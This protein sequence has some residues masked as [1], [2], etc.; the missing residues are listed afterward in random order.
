MEISPIL[1]L[2]IPL[3]AGIFFYGHFSDFF[4]SA[5]LMVMLSVLLLLLAGH[6]FLRNCRVQWI[7]GMGTALFMFLVGCVLMEAGRRR[8]KVEWFPE[9]AVYGGIVQEVPVEKTRSIQYKIRINERDVLLYLSIDSLSRSVDIGDSLLFYA[10]VSEPV[11]R[12]D[13][14]RWDYAEYLRFHGIGGTAY[15]APGCWKK[16]DVRS[17]LTWKQRALKLREGIVSAYRRWGMSEE[18]WPVLAAL[19]VGHKS[20]LDNELRNGYSAA[21]ISHVLALSGLHVGIV[22][23]LLG[24]LL[25]PLERVFKSHWP[26][27]LLGIILLWG[28]AYVAGLEAPVV[29]ATVMCMFMELGRLAGRKVLSVN[30]VS[31]AAFFMLLYNPFYLFDWGFLLSFAAVISIIMFYPLFRSL[32]HTDNHLL[33]WGWRVMAVS[34]AAQLGTA[35]LVMYFFSNFSVYFLLGNMLAAVIVPLIV[36]LSLFSLL[37][38]PFPVVLQG[39]FTLQ[40]YLVDVMNVTAY[41]ISEWPFARIVYTDMPAVGVFVAYLFLGSVWLYWKYPSGKSMIGMLAGIASMLC[42]WLWR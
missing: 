13:S 2:A 15:A 6:L 26:G 10:L 12:K 38:I 41:E 23:M 5:G 17:E 40:G 3:A 30:A 1:R 16:E 21:G 42:A 7:F 14:S 20:A 33:G 4:P 35:P 31:V 9:K 36:G 25:R 19:T 11:G 28:F 22:W 37:L 27:G 34:L 29:R 8:V 32:V 18:Q 39:V 24:G